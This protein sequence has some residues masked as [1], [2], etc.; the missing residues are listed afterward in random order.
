MATTLTT[1]KGFNLTGML[2]MAGSVALGLTIFTLVDKHFLS[3]M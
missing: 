3:K 1:T 2:V